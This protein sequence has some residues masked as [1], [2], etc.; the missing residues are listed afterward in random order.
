[1][2]AMLPIDRAKEKMLL[3]IGNVRV[4]PLSQLAT[5]SS[6]LRETSELAY[7][8]RGSVIIPSSLKILL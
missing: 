4:M 1:M 2:L 5:G 3:A 6:A 7:L 8:I